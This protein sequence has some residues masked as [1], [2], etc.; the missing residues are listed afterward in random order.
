MR[1]IKN[2]AELEKAVSEIEEVLPAIRQFIQH[3]RGAADSFAAWTGASTS[4]LPA[5]KQDQH[6]NVAA[7]GDTLTDKVFE[8]VKLAG[9]PITAAGATNEYS[10]KWPSTD[11]RNKIYG[12]VSGALAYLH[13]KK[14]LLEKDGLKYSVSKNG[15]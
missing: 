10:T 6:L 5:T 12:K 9:G 8:I 4:P 7:A 14:S 1:T 15:N 11:P 2:F 3:V 13:K